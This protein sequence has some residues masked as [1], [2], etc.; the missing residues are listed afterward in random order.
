MRLPTRLPVEHITLRSIPEASG[1]LSLFGTASTLLGELITPNP[2]VMMSPR[3]TWEETSD[4]EAKA[5]R[6]VQVPLAQQSRQAA[7]GPDTVRVKNEVMDPDTKGTVLAVGAVQ[8]SRSRPGSRR[9]WR[10]LHGT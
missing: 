7:A 1:S 8:L 2:P 6:N 9:R 5:A 3:S 10:S 4:G